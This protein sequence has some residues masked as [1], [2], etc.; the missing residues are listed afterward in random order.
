MGKV[1]FPK[2]FLWGAAV[3]AE[4]TEGKGTTKKAKTIY[5]YHYEK[6]PNAFHNQIGPDVTS[7]FMNRFRGD[8]ALMA[9]HKVNSFRTSLSWARLFPEGDYSKPSV[10]GVKFYHELI[11]ECKK[12]NIELILTLFHFDLPMYA[13]EKGGFESR[14]VWNDFLEY[15]KFCFHE[16]GSKVK[17][18]TT[19]NEPLVPVQTGY[20]SGIQMPLVKDDQRAVNAAYGIFMAHALVVNYFNKEIKKQ[21][22]G[23]KIGGIFNAT[24]VY[25]RSNDSEDVK[26]AEYL[27]L[28]QFTGMTDAMIAGKLNPELVKWI[29][30]MDLVPQNYQESDLK[31]LGQVELDIIG[32]NFYQPFRAKKSD[33]EG[34]SKFSKYFSYYNMPGRR[35][36][37]FR[38]WEIYPEALYDTMKIIADRYGKDKEFILSEYGMGVE[39]ESLFRNANGIIDDQ[40]RIAFM[41]EHLD[42]LHRAMHE[43]NL[44]VIGAHAWAMF[45]CWSWNNAYKNR[46]GL[47]EVNL[48]DQSRL[49]K[50]SLLFLEEVVNN[51]GYD[52]EYEKMEKYMDFDQVGFTKSVGIDE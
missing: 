42:Q 2:D 1:N 28:F 7:D 36:N 26:A 27:T 8:I 51:H 37:K 13:M 4:Q 41:K 22:P 31:I 5:E 35:E 9:K 39:N 33:T 19:M 32:L 29:K 50:S 30:E 38:G 40:Y 3:S 10:E 48:K 18:W 17:I 44:K 16:F 15:S 45:D 6:N 21:F 20:L 34:K 12:N 49:P 47:I 14:E 25:P 23:N 52:G 11:D 46:Y 43:L 24:V